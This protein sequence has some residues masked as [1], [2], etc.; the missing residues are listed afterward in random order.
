L[1]KEQFIEKIEILLNRTLKLKKDG[2]QQVV[3]EGTCGLVF[4]SSPLR[5]KLYG[6]TGTSERGKAGLFD[7][8]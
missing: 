4:L 1:E 6:K 2:M 7:N 8:S 3:I 5:N